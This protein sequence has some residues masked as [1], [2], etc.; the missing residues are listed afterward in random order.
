MRDVSSEPEWRQEPPVLRYEPGNENMA[1]SGTRLTADS[2]IPQTG[3]RSRADA[4]SVG[5]RVLPV[6]AAIIWC[7]LCQPWWLIR[8]TRWM[9]PSTLEAERRQTRS[10]THF[11]AAVLEAG[12]AVG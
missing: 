3:H 11:L 12:R 4:G 7:C 2:K 8:L 10:R 1:E 5:P 9:W 6:Q